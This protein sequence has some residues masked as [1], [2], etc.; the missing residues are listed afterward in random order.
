MPLDETISLGQ[1]GHIADHQR[2]A[3]QLN[4]TPDLPPDTAHAKDQEFNATSSSLP[5]GWTWLNQ[6]TATYSEAKGWG[7]I[8]LPTASGVN[9]RGIVQTV[10]AVAAYT[11]VAKVTG[12]IK[13]ANNAYFGI[14]ITDGT[15]VISLTLDSAYT[16]QVLRW[17]TVTSFTD[18][19]GTAQD[20]IFA[21]PMWLRI[22]KNS[23]TSYDFAF[24]P[25]GSG[26]RDRLAAY[27]VSA[28]M[29][30][31]HL[32]VFGRNDDTSQTALV[33]IDYLRVTEP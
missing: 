2:V 25:N 1:S 17:A 11:A 19:L 23:V 4:A 31:T 32:M 16:L 20:S 5:S 6:G 7:N 3:A 30:P 22:R 26:W 27:D 10:P 18:V 21:L 8:L 15:K 14:G 13:D 24:S 29:T 28:W 33:G 9:V 12:L